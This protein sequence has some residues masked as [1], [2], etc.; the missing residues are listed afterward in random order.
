MPLH[1]LFSRLFPRQVAVTHRERLLSALGAFAAVL[2]LAALS[3]HLIDAA[4]APILAA[5]MGASAVLLLGVPH[6][7]FSQP[8]AMVGGHL[9]AALVG[10]TCAHFIPDGQVAAGAA[11]GGTVLAMFY[12]RC[13][14]PPSGGTALLCVIGGPKI[15][16]L[17][18]VFALTPVLLNALT[19]LAAALLINRLIPHRHYPTPHQPPATPAPASL[20]FG[21]ADLIAALEQIDEVIDVTEEDLE[22]IYELASE[23]ATRRRASGAT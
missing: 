20:G 18:Y 10:I 21:H 3:R 11:V 22:H 17:G 8:W 16:A 14:H 5:S 13:L 1:H 23:I 9:V 19:L 2:V 15:Q 6:S 7:P 4:D 12:L